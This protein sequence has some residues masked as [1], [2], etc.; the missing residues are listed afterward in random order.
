MDVFTSE[1][2]GIDCVL[3]TDTQVYTYYI[4]N[5]VAKLKGEGDLHE[6]DISVTAYSQEILLTGT[7]LYS[8][9]S[10]EYTLTLYPTDSFFE[11]Y[12]TKNPAIAAF[13]AAMCIIVTSFFFVFYDFYFLIDFNAKR[14]LLE[15]KRKFVRFVSHEGKNSNRQ[16]LNLRTQTKLTLSG[17]LST[18]TS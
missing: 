9:T 18:H 4:E 3:R 12:R 11:V 1:V 2:S 5:G 8:D 6:Q 14:E 17:N 10:V 15:A 13:A 7:G 16:I